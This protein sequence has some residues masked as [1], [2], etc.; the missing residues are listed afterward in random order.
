MSINVKD[1]IK[2]GFAD[3]NDSS[4]STTPVTLLANTWTDI[5]NDGLGAFTN[6]KSLPFG[7]NQLMDNSTGYIDPTQLFIGD[8]IFVRN[9]YT[10]TPSVNNSLLKFR[11]ELGTGAGI[12]QLETIKG[13]LDSGSGVG[14]RLAL[15]PD[16]IY[17][18]DS[19]TKDNYIKI[20]VNLENDGTLVN[21]GTVIQVVKG[22]V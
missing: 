15:K 9:D 17:M 16:L 2:N 19:N 13:R 6:L 14:Y 1:K 5:P 10:I 18:G 7:I 11:Y 4:T 22:G 12:Y 3:Y 20:Q 8:T 21:A